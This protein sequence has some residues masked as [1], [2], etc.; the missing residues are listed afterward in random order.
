SKKYLELCITSGKFTNT[1]GE[2]DVK[3]GESDGALFRKIRETYKETRKSLLPTGYIFRKPVAAIFV[4]VSLSVA[5]KPRCSYKAPS[6]PP[7]EQVDNGQYEY[8]PCPIDA[9]PMTS[10]WFMHHFD[11]ID[12][13]RHP[14]EIWGP[15]LP[16]KLGIS[17]AASTELLAQGWGIRIE[18]GPNW[19]LLSILMFLFILIS[20]IVAGAYAVKTHD[21]QAA[22]AIGTW[23][24][25]VQAMGMAALF[26]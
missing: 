4:K 1:L 11:F 3:D 20:G 14:E 23:L 17:L 6:I 5:S 13:P 8:R 10:N 9:P 12:D 15:R 26:F 7:K 16:K 19:A 2:V 22:V 21:N 18:E 25:T 24:T